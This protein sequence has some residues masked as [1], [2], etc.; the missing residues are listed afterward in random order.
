MAPLACSFH[1]TPPWV[2]GYSRPCQR[3]VLRYDDEILKQFGFE[4]QLRG[5][6]TLKLIDCG[7]RGINH[8]TGAIKSISHDT[9]CQ[10]LLLTRGRA[11]HQFPVRWDQCGSFW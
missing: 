3:R 9:A 7:T 2:N 4:Q 1:Q 10:H 11:T 8:A 6:L 5:L